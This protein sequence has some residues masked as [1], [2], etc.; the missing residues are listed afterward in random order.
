MSGNSNSIEP[1][2]ARAVDR[3]FARLLVRY[4]AAWIRLWDGLDMAFVKEDWSRELA[5]MDFDAIAYALDNLPDDKPPPT[6]TAFRKLAINR[7]AYYRPALPEPRADR[8]RVAAILSNLKIGS[9]DDRAWAREL[10]AREEAGECLTY[11]QRKAWRQAM[12]HR[13]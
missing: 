12:G 6:A 10:A 2:P 11:T 1:L 5:G 8:A 4:G 9:S 13:D 3:I 7:P